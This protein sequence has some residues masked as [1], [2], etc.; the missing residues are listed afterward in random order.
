MTIKNIKKQR[1]FLKWA[2]GKYNLVEKITQLL[3]KRAETLVEP[4]VGAGS[5]FLNTNYKQYILND[6]NPDLIGLYRHLQQRPELLIK[7]CAKLYQS[8]YNQA[9]A[10][11]ALR[12]DFNQETD[13][14]RRAILFTYL[15]R[16]GYNGLCRY[17]S[18]GNYNVPF[19]RYVKPYFPEAEMYTFAEKAQNAV[20]TQ[21]DFQIC[22]QQAPK[23]A[24]IYCD[25]P[26]VSLSDTANFT[27]YA[28][29]GFAYQDQQR[30]A[31]TAAELAHKGLNT[32]LISNHDTPVSRHLYQTANIRSTKVSRVIS[33]KVENRR[34]VKEVLALYKVGSLHHPSKTL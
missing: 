28:R 4:F 25:P 27:Q 6:I 15:N 14:F 31:Q 12:Q 11:Y 1:A 3:P 24:V 8:Q 2:G 18:S 20:F 13:T 26:Y 32:V 9:D 22:M 33:Q 34:A 19:G 5:V 29:A 21:I 7:E 23:G 16:H 30:L 17:N 10:Y